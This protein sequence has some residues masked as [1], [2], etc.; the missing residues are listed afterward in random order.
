M[1]VTTHLV[2]NTARTK[3]DEPQDIDFDDLDDVLSALVVTLGI[4]EP[5]ALITL[6]G[7]EDSREAHFLHLDTLNTVEL[8]LASN[9]G[10]LHLSG[11][12]P[13]GSTIL[14][15]TLRKGGI[16]SV[17]DLTRIVALVARFLRTGE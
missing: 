8:N 11:R 12:T 6:V 17:R 7:S 15:D 14:S 5:N 16:A 3:V 10:D 13:D 1:T 4:V 9:A 2:L